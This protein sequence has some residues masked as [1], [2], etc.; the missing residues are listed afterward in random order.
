MCRKNIYKVYTKI[1]LRFSNT[2]RGFLLC[3]LI[4]LNWKSNSCQ[5]WGLHSIVVSAVG[6]IEGFKPTN[7]QNIPEDKYFESRY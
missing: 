5:I 3:R 6:R 7:H 1:L 2:N 4:A